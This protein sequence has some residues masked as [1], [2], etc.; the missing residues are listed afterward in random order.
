MTHRV[1]EMYLKL[2]K[3]KSITAEAV[4]RIMG[5]ESPSN[6][7]LVAINKILEKRMQPEYRFNPIKAQ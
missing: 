7:E 3:M 5:L 4:D 6:E 2:G 1:N